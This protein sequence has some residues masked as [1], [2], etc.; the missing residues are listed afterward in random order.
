MKV[1]GLAVEGARVF[2][3]IAAV[4]EEVLGVEG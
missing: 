1:E 3:A 2:T 4:E